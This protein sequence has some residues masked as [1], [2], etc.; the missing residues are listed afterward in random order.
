MAIVRKHKGISVFLTKIS[1]LLN[2]VCGSA[3][4]KDIM[5]EINH[6]QLTKALGCGQLETGRG[7]NQE[8]YLQRPGDT[9]WNSHYKN[10]KGLVDMFSTIIEVLKVMEKDDRDWKNRDQAS[11]LLVYFQ[12]FDIVFYLHLMLTTLSITNILS[13]ALQRKDQDIVNANKC[14][15]VTRINLDDLRKDGWTNY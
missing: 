1:I 13:L 2:V 6:E 8:Q 15:K 5:R 12:S 10:L 9:H 3:K 14:V 7:L 4:R 11:N